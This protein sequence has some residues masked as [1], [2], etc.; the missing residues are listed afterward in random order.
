MWPSGVFWRKGR[1]G[2]KGIIE[3][4][5]EYK[6]YSSRRVKRLYGREAAGNV[7]T[8][9]ISCHTNLSYERDIARHRPTIYQTDPRNIRKLRE[10][11]PV[12][13]D[14]GTPPHMISWG[15]KRYLRY[16]SV[17]GLARSTRKHSNGNA[18]LYIVGWGGAR[19]VM[20]T[21]RIGS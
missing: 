19:I 12:S 21:M 10:S 7:D 6:L 3:K 20:G 4:T 17:A 14:M 18:G 13:R 11:Q 1:K 9:D 2:N 16:V 8:M 5:S 15:Q